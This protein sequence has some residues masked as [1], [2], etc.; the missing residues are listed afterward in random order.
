M[1]KKLL[2]IL[3]HLILPAF[4]TGVISFFFTYIIMDDR[5]R[6]FSDPKYFHAAILISLALGI[7]FGAMIY[8]G[9]ISY[10]KSQRSYTCLDEWHSQIKNTEDIFEL[11]SYIETLKN[12]KRSSKCPSMMHVQYANGIIATAKT[13]VDTIKKLSID[14]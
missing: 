1:K 9:M 14:K 7:I 8:L 10:R 4:S 6:L 11:E 3:Y 12:Y 5:R 13:K 2:D